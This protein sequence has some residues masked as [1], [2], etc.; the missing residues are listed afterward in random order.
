MAA[1][2]LVLARAAAWVLN[3]STGTFIRYTA[4][5]MDPNTA[6][7]RAAPISRTVEFTAE[8]APIRLGGRLSR[9]TAVAGLLAQGRPRPMRIWAMI[10]GH[11]G[12][13]GCTK[14]VAR[15]RPVTTRVIPKITVRLV[16][17]RSTH[18][19]AYRAKM[20]WVTDREIPASAAPNGLNPSTY[21]KSWVPKKNHPIRAKNKRAIA[22]APMEKRRSQNHSRS[23][24]G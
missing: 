9:T 6:I 23:T 10:N 2:R 17:S 22:K 14:K 5:E 15:M 21:W 7:P 24:N 11:N 20:T 1:G 19:A 8:P 13:S 12:E 16:P 18:T 3:P 4:V